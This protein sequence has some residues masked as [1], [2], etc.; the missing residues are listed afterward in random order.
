MRRCNERCQRAWD[1]D[2]KYGFFR[3]H[4]KFNSLLMQSCRMPILIKLLDELENYDPITAFSKENMEHPP[5]TPREIALPSRTRR[6]EAIT[7]HEGIYKALAQRNLKA[8][9][10]ALQHHLDKV[11]ESCLLGVAAYRMKLEDD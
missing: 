9:R 8:Y 10:K 7:E 11:E 4:D 5:V 3:Y 1:E 2:D 6:Y